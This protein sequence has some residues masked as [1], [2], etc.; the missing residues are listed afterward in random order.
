MFNLIKENKV[1]NK[2]KATLNNEKSFKSVKVYQKYY[3]YLTNIFYLSKLHM[4][5][6]F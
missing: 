1:I 5:N 3:L 4:E 6:V 2:E